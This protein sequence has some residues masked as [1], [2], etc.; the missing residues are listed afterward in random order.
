[1]KLY[2]Y[3]PTLRFTTIYLYTFDTLEQIQNK[4]VEIYNSKND[5]IQLKAKQITAFYGYKEIEE[6]DTISSYNIDNN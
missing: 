5:I 1:M 4:A 3:I 6:H 2:L